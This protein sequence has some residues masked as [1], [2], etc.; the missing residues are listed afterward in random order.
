MRDRRWRYCW[1]DASEP[2]AAAVVPASDEEGPAVGAKGKRG[3]G[4]GEPGKLAS[5]SSSRRPPPAPSGDGFGVRAGAPSVSLADMGWGSG[6]AH[7]CA[8]V[9]EEEGGS[10]LSLSSSV[11]FR[12]VSNRRLMMCVRGRT[13][14]GGRSKKAG[15]GVVAI[16]VEGAL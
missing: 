6:A 9:G 8:W 1:E 10:S 12:V 14:G 15:G 5:E 4:K 13:F 2:V 3:E 16:G 11:F 7:C